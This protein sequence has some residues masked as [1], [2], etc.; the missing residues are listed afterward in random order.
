M[1]MHSEVCRWL[2]GQIARRQARGESCRAI[3]RTLGIARKTVRTLI[4]EEM[5]R[6][7]AGA[8]ALVRVAKPPR[9]PRRSKLD[10][11]QTRIDFWLQFL[12]VLEAV[13]S[14]MKRAVIHHSDY[15]SLNAMKCAISRHF[16]ERNEY[17]RNN[18]K[19][20]GKKIWDLD[21]FHDVEALR[22]GDYREW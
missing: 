6:L 7:A 15:D 12:D 3:G 19:R 20:A 13:F 2:A 11:F 5:L 14:G 16:M 21:F 9:V 4:A 18:P 10:R 17:F 1:P 22:A 8:S